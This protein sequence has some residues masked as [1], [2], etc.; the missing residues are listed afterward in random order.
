MNIELN[1]GLWDHLQFRF[2]LRMML[3]I[4]LSNTDDIRTENLLED[5][6]IELERV[7]E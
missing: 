6:M 5:L 3:L 4:C 7:G 1:E 2:H